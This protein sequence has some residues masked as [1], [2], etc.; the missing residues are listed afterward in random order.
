MRRRILVF[1]SSTSCT[2]RNGNL[3]DLTSEQ[4]V[5]ANKRRGYVLRYK[6]GKLEN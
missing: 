6:I 3:S 5:K 2:K 1:Y 4:I